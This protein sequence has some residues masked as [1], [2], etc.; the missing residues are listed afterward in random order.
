[1]SSFSGFVNPGEMCYA[2]SVIQQLRHMQSFQAFL[3]TCRKSEESSPVLTE[4]AVLLAHDE[5]RLADVSALCASLSDEDHRFD[6]GEQ[7]D[8]SD[9]A[10]V[11]LQHISSTTNSNLSIHK[12]FKESIVTGMRNDISSERGVIIKRD[13]SFYLSVD[14]THDCSSLENSLENLFRATTFDFLWAID[15]VASEDTGTER[16]TT[17]T[18]TTTVAS[19]SSSSKRKKVSLP[20][21]KALSIEMFPSHF[22]FHIRRFEFDVSTMGTKKKNLFYEFPHRID[23]SQY[24][25]QTGS[26]GESEQESG[27]KFVYELGGVI[28]HKGE[29]DDGHYYSLVRDRKDSESA[30]WWKMNDES[31]EPFDMESLEEVAFGGKLYTSGDTVDSDRLPSEAGGVELKKPKRKFK[32]RKENAFMLVYDRVPA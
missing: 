7:K 32:W 26:R 30:R 23:M 20:T 8:A 18:S 4:L 17:T 31:V 9:F 27:E 2:I 24:G 6:E 29:A 12:N 28:V 15:D 10:S 14:V 11:L 1:M 16:N 3:A 25:T 5:E 13:P 19:S 22:L 21:T